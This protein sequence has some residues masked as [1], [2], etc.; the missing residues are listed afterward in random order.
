MRMRG[1]S[2]SWFLLNNS[3]FWTTPMSRML[4][5]WIKSWVKRKN[6]FR[7]D[8]C[9]G[10]LFELGLQD[11]HP[12]FQLADS[13]RVFRRLS[14]SR[15]LHVLTHFFQLFAD[16]FDLR[17]KFYLYKLLLRFRSQ[18]SSF[19]PAKCGLRPR[20]S[21]NTPVGLLFSLS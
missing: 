4:N 12:P 13:W 21:S 16:A 15:L 8:Y 10:V 11:F 20:L 9:F 2:S 1:L 3:S 7:A 14:Y 6:L 19:S 18:V 5:F 17:V